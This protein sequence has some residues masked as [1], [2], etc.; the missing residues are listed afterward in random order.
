MSTPGISYLGH[1][2][3]NNPDPVSHPPQQL[4]ANNAWASMFG[5]P[6][7]PINVHPYDRNNRSTWILPEG[8][9]G[10]SRFLGNT[11][12]LVAMANNSFILNQILPIVRA[13]GPLQ[14]NWSRW[15]FPTQLPDRVPER[16]IV[17][18]IRSNRIQG[19]EA[20]VRYGIGLFLEHGFMN[21]P[22]GRQHYLMHLKQ[23]NESVSE[24]LQFQGLYAIATVEDWAKRFLKEHGDYHSDK[25]MFD[26]M[27]RELRLWACLQTN[28][29]GMNF[30]DNLINQYNELYN[31]GTVLTTYLM[32]RRVA[33]FLSIIPHDQVTYYLRGS[34]AH[35][36]V[37][38]GPEAFSSDE[39]GNRIYVTR[40]YIADENGPITPFAQPT[41][42]GE[43]FTSLDRYTGSSYENY[44]TEDR[45]LQYYNQNGD[46]FSVLKLSEMLE[47]CNRFDPNTG[48]LIHIN[49]LTHG[50]RHYSPDEKAADFL[51]YKDHNGNLQTVRYFGQINKHHIGARDY[52][53]AGHAATHR[54]ARDLSTSPGEMH[55]RIQVASRIIERMYNTP[56]DTDYNN[57]L[58]ALGRQNV[59]SGL[60]Q[61]SGLIS[62]NQ[63]KSNV[64]GSLDL[65]N[66]TGSTNAH[67]SAIGELGYAGKWPLPPTHLTYGGFKTIADAYHSN[68]LSSMGFRQDEGKE[69]ADFV[70]WFDQS[71]NYLAKYYPDSIF[72]NGHYAN[73]WVARPTGKDT[74]F[75][76]LFLQGKP[77]HPIFLRMGS[78]AKDA[79]FGN[80]GIGIDDESARV[81]STLEQEFN[82]GTA[83]RQ[84]LMDRVLGN[85]TTKE[86][87]SNSGFIGASITGETGKDTSV[88]YARDQVGPD[89]KFVKRAG[90][91]AAQIAQMNLFVQKEN[92][93]SSYKLS[94]E[95]NLNLAIFA[96]AGKTKEERD[97]VNAYR[98]LVRWA[99]LL[100]VPTKARNFSNYEELR[101][102]IR[103]IGGVTMVL[104]TFT[105]IKINTDDIYG[106]MESYRKVMD[107]MEA[108]TS[109]Q[110]N[111]QVNTNEFDAEQMFS[112]SNSHTN[113]GN[114]MIKFF[115]NN[116][117]V[118]TDEIS[119]DQLLR[120]YKSLATSANSLAD[121]RSN[122]VQRLLI[123][124]PTNSLSTRA[125]DNVK[126]A[127]NQLFAQL[128]Q[129]RHIF[130][131]APIVMG[132]GALRTFLSHYE[133]T[134][135]QNLKG[136]PSLFGFPS[137][138]DNTLA[139][140][141]PS[142]LFDSTKASE[143]KAFI[144]SRGSVAAAS[145]N[146]T[147][148]SAFNPDRKAVAQNIIHNSV[149]RK[150]LELQ[151]TGKFDDHT[152]NIQ[153]DYSRANL[154]NNISSTLGRSAGSQSI[155]ARFHRGF[156]QSSH[157]KKLEQQQQ[158]SNQQQ[159]QN[160]LSST[161]SSKRK[162]L[163]DVFSHRTED[164]EKSQDLL[165]QST[166]RSTKQRKLVSTRSIAIQG[167]GD[168]GAQRDVQ[169][170][171]NKEITQNF[172]DLYQEI[173]KD[174]TGLVRIIAL[175]ALG[176]PVTRQALRATI[177]YD[178]VHLFN[179]I[180]SR[181]HARYLGIAVT[182]MVPGIGT[183]QTNLGHVKAEVGDDPTTGVHNANLTYYS[184]SQITRPKNISNNPNCL[185]VDY[186]GGLGSGFYERGD[187]YRPND[188][189]YGHSN[190]DS[191]F[192]FAY[193]RQEKIEAN[194][195]SLTG[196][197][198]WLNRNAYSLPEQTFSGLTHST[199]PFYSMYWGFLKHRWNS[200]LDSTM[201]N[202]YQIGERSIPNAMTF[203][204]FSARY[205]SKQGTYT[206]YTNQTGHWKTHTL[207]PGAHDARIGLR[208]FANNPIVNGVD[209]M[210]QV[211]V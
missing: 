177:R 120:V 19:S 58:R 136:V 123:K 5:T 76:A 13:D 83:S 18:V 128:D 53:D 4:A 31:Q 34:G 48:E 189:V 87:V 73:S 108:A 17:R 64:H 77:V 145:A 183:G 61:T 160:T 101:K 45:Q 57:F 84:F 92:T 26:V 166:R 63:W 51:H 203:G 37:R 107:A 132:A 152:P 75:A 1:S 168:F 172:G 205:N 71:Y 155:N 33:N 21:T 154:N 182:K 127:V 144:G 147:I 198:Q 46:C 70:V 25:K 111:G 55:R 32:D 126:T 12:T 174:E 74:L 138:S 192:V 131:R 54:L 14:S 35:E 190:N 157:L 133:S 117:K 184:S 191:F 193:P 202:K 171:L 8:L 80:T 36:I 7:V 163:S 140:I 173:S 65:P 29:N 62:I 169:A 16:G 52:V 97:Y 99:I 24:G 47:H 6:D 67:I 116:P 139:P 95:D 179:Y 82:Q 43:H 85:L 115:R 185:I 23:I 42:I 91:D 129:Q 204:S 113:F 151:N 148:G 211:A 124:E 110:V 103:G 10:Q 104:L 79:A 3:F 194:P 158:Y 105:L 98:D 114:A 27:E 102:A 22:L 15:E 50:A 134:L 40:G 96:A 90:N 210:T 149:V 162:R 66:Y 69:V 119:V 181:P 44:R 20:M 118:L 59:V 146:S 150:A 68:T 89:G 209:R 196:K 170:F 38:D 81:I 167:S 176:T 94:T 199:A 137:G 188:N 141:T 143:L 180:C 165:M 30:L 121:R 206:E 60:E 159:A 93:L 186:Y 109:I 156:T 78:G 11:L 28:R 164:I 161:S 201:Y 142:E 100:R 9:R 88:A 208:S 195:I 122:L 135:T 207:G 41:Q 130:H 49:R 106:T 112:Q 197:Y 2:Q 175:I 187:T 153:A 200:P 86:R 178:L 39:R 72:L 56:F 125:V